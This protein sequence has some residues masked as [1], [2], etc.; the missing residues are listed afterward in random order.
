MIIQHQKI[1][2][3]NKP[4]IEKVTVKSPFRHSLNYPDDAC[5]IYFEEGK[6][7][8]NSAYEQEQI[9]NK[10]AVLL[11]CGTYFSDLIP[12]PQSDMFK[13]LVFH[14]PKEIIR[15]IYKEQFPI[16]SGP[17]QMTFIHKIDASRILYEFIKGLQ[18]YFDNPQIVNEELLKLKI[19]ELILLLLQTHIAET[20][21]DLFNG[22]FSATEI[23]MKQVVY[24][25]IFSNLSITDLAGL[26]NMSLA[27][28]NRQFKKLFNDTPSSFFKNK[29]LEK[30]KELI[31]ASDITIGEIAFETCFSDVAHFSR[32]FKE[33]FGCTPTEYRNA[34]V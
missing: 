21:K 31:K 4:L 19:K 3:G 24:S 26:S 32:S 27:T 28:F 30:A 9:I 5:F 33:K 14:L 13:I 1:D 12:Q 11:K 10:E 22:L 15:E 7:K 23:N 17:V 25:H 29:R 6:A 20:I 18:F 8:I 16:S 34:P 2:F